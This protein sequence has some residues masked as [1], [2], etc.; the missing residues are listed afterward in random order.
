MRS[1]FLKLGAVDT[2]D[3]WYANDGESTFD[4]DENT[5]MLY[6]CLKGKKIIAQVPN[7]RSAGEYEPYV[8]KRKK[9]P[10]NFE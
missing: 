1:V 10:Q 7:I 9:L 6:P 4:F 2:M 8:K 5:L 3:I